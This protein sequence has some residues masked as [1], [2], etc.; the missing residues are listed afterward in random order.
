[1]KW[2]AMYSYT[3][4]ELLQV[5][6]RLGREPDVIITNNARRTQKYDG[7]NLR[8]MPY[9]PHASDYM[10]IFENIMRG[11]D[12][13]IITLHGWN[14]IIPGVICE[15]YKIYN[16]HPGDIINY[17]ILKGADPQAKAVELK[18]H[19]SG[20][21]IHE[22]TAELD[23]GPIIASTTGV[24]IEGMDVNTVTSLLRDVSVDMWVDLLPDILSSNSYI[25][26]GIE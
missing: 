23:S 21:I 11:D 24:D 2:I 7:K 26:M 1:M 4:S 13:Y 16:V 25:E 12:R 15:K 5:M 18:L 17:P 8:I 20:V 22:V 14:R 3:G 9:R 10:A 19:E 6:E